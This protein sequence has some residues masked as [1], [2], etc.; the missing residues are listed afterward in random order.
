MYMYMC[1]YMHMH[2]YMC[3]LC[4]CVFMSGS[5]RSCTNATNALAPPVSSPPFPPSHSHVLLPVAVKGGDSREQ[6]LHRLLRKGTL[7]AIPQVACRH[8]VRELVDLAP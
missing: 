4:G 5:L 1:M 8:K 7:R 3:M 2:M 6:S